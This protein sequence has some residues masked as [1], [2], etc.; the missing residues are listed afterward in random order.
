MYDVTTYMPEFLMQNVEMRERMFTMRLS[1]DESHRLDRLAGHYGLNA[2]GLFRMLLKR[3][4]RVLANELTD[5]E[6]KVIGPA[7]RITELADKVTAA[8]RKVTGI[9]DQVNRKKRRNEEK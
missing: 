2:A 7:K 9:A 5:V 8:S 6:D 1:E 4:E 3:E